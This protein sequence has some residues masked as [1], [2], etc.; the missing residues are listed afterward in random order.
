M[1]LANGRLLTAGYSGDGASS[2]RIWQIAPVPTLAGEGL[3]TAADPLC[4][5]LQ[6]AVALPQGVGRPTVLAW[7]PGGELL[8]T[9]G[10]GEVAHWTIGGDGTGAARRRG[11][12]LP[13]WSHRMAA[14]SCATAAGPTGQIWRLDTSGWVQDGTLPGGA[15]ADASWTDYGILA[16][17][18]DGSAA[19]IDPA[20]RPPPGRA[21]RYG[22]EWVHASNR[23]PAGC[24]AHRTAA[25]ELWQLG[26]AQPLAGWPIPPGRSLRLDDVV[27]ESAKNGQGQRRE[28]GAAR[29]S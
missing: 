11:S 12:P 7:R 6:R 14:A 29:L 25:V 26:D 5:R 15:L 13:L 27:K 10:D 3:P 19:V 16:A 24:P 22:R 9:G 18:A 2:L 8:T 1:R 21:G 28:S 23:G 4:R 20:D 17:F